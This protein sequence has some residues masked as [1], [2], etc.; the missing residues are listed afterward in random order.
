MFSIPL[1][2]PSNHMSYRK[3]RINDETRIFLWV[4]HGQSLGNAHIDD[5]SP[6]PDGITETAKPAAM[7]NH[8]VHH[9]PLLTPLGIFQA[10]L[11]AAALWDK[12]VQNGWEHRDIAVHVSPMLRAKQTAEPFVQ[13]LA[14]KDVRFV[15]IP[16]ERIHEFFQ[17]E[18]SCGGALPYCDAS[19]GDFLDRASGW[20]ESAVES[21]SMPINFVFGHSLFIS[22]ALQRILAGRES[23]IALA[24]D[25][26]RMPLHLS[27]CSISETLHFAADANGTDGQEAHE[28]KG[29]RVATPQALGIL[30]KFNDHA[31]LPLSQ[32]SGVHVR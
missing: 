28:P 14:V 29:P 6:F 31:H 18:E 25:I 11:T 20:V 4:R 13:L 7:P 21:T 8:E 12:I 9:D 22:A 10:H 30:T 19:P 16:D 24:A 5:T 23:L 2:T 26:H 15:V 17:A 32:K 1:R 27:N 3:L